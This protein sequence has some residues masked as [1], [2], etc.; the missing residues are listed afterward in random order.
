MLVVVLNKSFGDK[1][2]VHYR[3]LW[4]RMLNFFSY[5]GSVEND[6]QL[7]LKC[8]VTVSQW[9]W[10]EKKKTGVEPTSRN[11]LGVSAVF[12]GMNVGVMRLNGEVNHLLA[13][14]LCIHLPSSMFDLSFAFLCSVLTNVSAALPFPLIPEH[15]RACANDR[16]KRRG[17]HRHSCPATEL[18]KLPDKA[19][20]SHL[21]SHSQSKLALP[22]YSLREAAQSPAAALSEAS[23]CSSF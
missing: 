9:K 8:C 11:Y 23:I 14:S 1:G 5:H 6:R 16:D 13:Y 19:A 10:D 21:G 15:T 2:T 17:R 22:I 7:N 4:H 3:V 12:H 20:R 18:L